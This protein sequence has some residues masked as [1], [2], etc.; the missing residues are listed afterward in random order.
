MIHRY[1]ISHAMASLHRNISK[2][3]KY[4]SLTGD[5]LPISD[6]AENVAVHYPNAII[7]D[8]I[9]YPKVQTMDLL[10]MIQ[11]QL[12]FHIVKLPYF[13]STCH[14]TNPTTGA[15]TPN[16]NKSI[17][18]NKINQLPQIIN[19]QL[20]RSSKPLSGKSSAYAIQCKGISQGSILS[21]ILC[22]LYYSYVESQIFPPS[23]Y[24]EQ[25]HIYQIHDL[26]YP[27]NTLILRM[28]DDYLIIST[29]Q[30][31]VDLFL[32][33][34]FNSY[35]LYGGKFNTLK[36]KLNY[37][38]TLRTCDG[39]VQEFTPY[40]TIETSNRITW[41]G[42]HIHC[43][44]LEIS[45]DLSRLIPRSLSTL[46][47]HQSTLKNSFYQSYCSIDSEHYHRAFQRILK[48]FFRS[49]C[50]AYILDDHINRK[51]R[52]MQSLLSLYH[53]VAIRSVIYLQRCKQ[54]YQIQYTDQF[55]FLSLQEAIDFAANLLT[56]RTMK[57]QNRWLR[58]EEEIS[59]CS[60]TKY[61]HSTQYNK[62]NQCFSY[63]DDYMNEDEEGAEKELNL[64]QGDHFQSEHHCFSRKRIQGKSFANE[65]TQ[66][67][68]QQQQKDEP[69]FGKC[70]VS[71]IL[72]SQVI[73]L[74]SLLTDTLVDTFVRQNIWLGKRFIMYIISIVNISY[75]H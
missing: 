9:I 73:T 30:S 17:N 28:M 72:V 11:Q 46:Q 1:T 14:L 71:P 37:S 19:H 26:S 21:P 59:P 48:S 57:K 5:F 32:Q 10:Q 4:V 64:Y 34:A 66:Q 40:T 65:T 38:T 35:R 75:R 13:Q 16:I 55:V 45:P 7:T 51:I 63:N 31:N 53:M 70:M 44:N 25:K 67:H 36:T 27:E 12:F 74:Y 49:K 39:T 43:D 18:N 29:E 61:G 50:H 8:N 20:H 54:I 62:K 6:T 22:H 15:A 2:P 56:T 23:Q 24:H 47:L 3:I 33:S 52:V 69:I 42:Y 60:D 41:C 68:Q 58:L